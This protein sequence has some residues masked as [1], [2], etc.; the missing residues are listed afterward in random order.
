MRSAALASIRLYQKLIS[1]YKG[2]CCA[3]RVHTGRASCSTLGYRAIRR[4]G[5][6]GG[7]TLIR[8]RTHLCGVAHRRHLSLPRRPLHPQQGVCDFG[9]DLPC[10]P[11]CDLPFGKVFS[12]A[13]DFVS[14]C[15][16]G[17]CDW[18]DRKRKTAVK[19]EQYV[20]IPPK[21]WSQEDRK[22]GSAGPNPS[23]ERTAPGKPGAASH[24]KR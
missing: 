14:C 22:R 19:D 10:D 13:C 5:V 15:D 9:C 4:Y 1:P 21:A 23:I 20:Y 16:C 6:L 17:S 8:S 2:F 11:S 7:I 3:Y 18:P 12:G 24:V